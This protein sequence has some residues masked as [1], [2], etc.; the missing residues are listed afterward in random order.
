MNIIERI[1][2]D[3]K[4][5]KVKKTKNYRYIAKT[6]KKEIQQ[7]DINVIYQICEYFLEKR[8]LTETIV[9][10]QIIYDNKN[11]YNNNTFD[12]FE[13]WLYAYI[14]DWWDCDDFMT[15]AFKHVLLMYPQYIPRLK[16]WV[17]H[18]KF[19]VRR[20]AAVILIMPARKGLI[21]SSII[22]GICDL[23]IHDTHYLVQKGY[24]WLLKE[25]SVK[26]HD[27]VINYLV[28][29]VKIMSRTAFRYA[30][31]KLQ[32]NEKKSLMKLEY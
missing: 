13:K 32:I 1:E 20:S 4:S 26:Y 22:F 12:V 3:I 25:A 24:G 27:E 19:A 7:L 6:Y 23:L 16:Q 9:A 11:K 15:H 8:K 14:H 5:I 10:Y 17:N 31:E 30:L 28:K 18:E 21:E 2:Q 29:N